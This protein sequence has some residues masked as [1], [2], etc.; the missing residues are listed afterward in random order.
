MNYMRTLLATCL[1]L[2]AFNAA[3]AA[4]SADQAARLGNNLT[5]IGAEKAANA[6]GSIPAY[7]GGLVTPPASFKSGDSMR[8]DPFAGEKPL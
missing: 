7:Q 8:P 3:H 1:S 4:V 6:D 5:Q 2:A